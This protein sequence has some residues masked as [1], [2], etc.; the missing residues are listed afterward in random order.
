[1]D[2][3]TDSKLWADDVHAVIH[4]LNLYHPVLSGWSYGPLVLLDYIRDYG[5]SQIGGLHFVGGVTKLGS[6]EAMSVL[7][8]EFLNL[9]PQ[10]L[11]TD[12]ETVARGLEGLL[13]LCFVR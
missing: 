4:S 10:F 3:Y 5:E 7:T 12:A 13:R 11:S 1:H 9:V 2:A 6:A 8:P